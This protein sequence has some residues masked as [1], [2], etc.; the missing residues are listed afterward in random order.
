MIVHSLYYKV[1]L[2]PEFWTLVDALEVMDKRW[3]GRPA[4]PGPLPSVSLAGSLAIQL[5]ELYDLSERE[6]VD[7]VLI[8]LGQEEPQAGARA[9]EQD[10]NPAPLSSTSHAEIVGHSP[11]TQGARLPEDSAA[12][13]STIFGETIARRIRPAKR[14]RESDW[15][16]R[17]EIPSAQ[18]TSTPAAALL[19]PAMPLS[20]PAAGRNVQP[21]P[22]PP[23][24]P[25]SN[26][27]RAEEGGAVDELS[28]IPHGLLD[29]SFLEMNRIINFD[30]F[31][32]MTNVDD[33]DLA[34]PEW[35]PG[36]GDTVPE[37]DGE[38]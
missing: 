4:Q 31:M 10:F 36:I 2:A 3:N 13:L 20:F 37:V 32:F 5:R 33:E 30:D 1:D 18:D 24:V 7:R 23:V 6:P 17:Q 25:R 16:S 28:A 8:L 26:I 21:G 27:L 12:E 22:S 29:E 35:L 15:A 11:R 9:A 19:S 34:R 14:P 38:E